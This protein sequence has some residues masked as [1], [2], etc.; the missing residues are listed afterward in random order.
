[1][2]RLLLAGLTLLLAAP[3]TGGEK[4]PKP[5]ITIIFDPAENVR[6]ASARVAVVG[7]P[8]VLNVSFLGTYPDRPLAVLIDVNGEYVGSTTFRRDAGPLHFR[9]TFSADDY[10]NA[11]FGGNPNDP[12][13]YDAENPSL[14]QPGVG[15]QAPGKEAWM[16][17]LFKV[18]Q[19]EFDKK[20][21][22]V[23]PGKIVVSHRYKVKLNCID[24]VA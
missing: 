11:M 16:E 5:R 23:R 13:G 4:A 19:I 9:Y 18:V 8:F 20:T 2:K 15:A 14:P 6:L 22:E 21:G 3:L 17:I 12:Q 7:Q 10:Y 1:M 24:C